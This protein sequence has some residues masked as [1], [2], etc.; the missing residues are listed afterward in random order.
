MSGQT[1]YGNKGYC[2]L[3]FFVFLLLFIATWAW[4]YYSNGDLIGTK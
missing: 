2:L 1:E 3:G 4:V